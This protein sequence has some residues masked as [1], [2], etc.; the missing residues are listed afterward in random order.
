[1]N[2]EPLAFSPDCEFFLSIGND[3]AKF[4]RRQS[5]VFLLPQ[6]ERCAARSVSVSDTPTY[7]DTRS[8]HPRRHN[9]ATRRRIP[10]NRLAR[11]IGIEKIGQ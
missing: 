5:I 7:I 1:M 8:R 4:F 11:I 9:R 2:N 6:S 3:F 10:L